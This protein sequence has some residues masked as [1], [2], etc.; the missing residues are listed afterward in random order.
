MFKSSGAGLA[1][2]PKTCHIS[3]GT[4]IPGTERTPQ[5][6]TRFCCLGALQAATRSRGRPDISTVQGRSVV[7]K[8]FSE[9]CALDDGDVVEDRELAQVCNLGAEAADGF[10]WVALQPPQHGLQAFGAEICSMASHQLPRLHRINTETAED[11]QLGAAQH[12][13]LSRAQAGS[14][15]ILNSRQ[16]PP[17]CLRRRC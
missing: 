14:T 12:R 13:A 15:R 8:G 1:S 6:V 4:S 2:S 16:A 5:D 10:R 11:L 3:A 7:A 9:M 17:P